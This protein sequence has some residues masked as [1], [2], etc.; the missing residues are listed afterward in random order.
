MT[1]P[2]RHAAQRIVSEPDMRTPKAY[3]YLTPPPILLYPASAIAT[4]RS[5]LR[6]D[7][8]QVRLRGSKNSARS[9]SKSKLFPLPPK[10]LETKSSVTR[11]PRIAAAFPRNASDQARPHVSMRSKEKPRLPFISTGPAPRPYQRRWRE[12]S[13][14]PPRLPKPA[15]VSSFYGITPYDVDSSPQQALALF[16]PSQA[17]APAKPPQLDATEFCEPERPGKEIARAQSARSLAELVARQ[18]AKITV[19]SPKSL[20]TIS[21][22]R[23]AAEIDRRSLTRSRR[24]SSSRLRASHRKDPAT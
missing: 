13:A 6:C 1:Q 5:S 20:C 22:R 19:L 21:H 11:R 18:S 23:T 9:K 10:A 16:D 24:N 12:K 4:W 14:A 7:Q 15:S 8:R 17:G 2:L 3:A